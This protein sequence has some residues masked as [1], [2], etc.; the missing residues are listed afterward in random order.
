MAENLHPLVLIHGLTF[1]RSTWQPLLDELAR[2]QPDRRV[3]ALDLPGHG[4]APRALSYDLGDV[5]TYVHDAAAA[6]HL[7]APILV[8]HSIG[9][10]VALIYAARFPTAAVVNLDQ[11]L[12]T[13]PFSALLHTLRPELEGPDFQA[14]W[15]RFRN[16]MGFD[17]LD[18]RM[19][20][21]VLSSHRPE[22]AL[23]VGYWQGVFDESPDALQARVDASLRMLADRRTPFT[24]V[25][26]RPVDPEY[27][28][29]LTRSVPQVR[30]ERFERSGH[31]PQLGDP[32]R[33]AE[34]LATLP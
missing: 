8:G 9:A 15:E 4:D 24:Y 32:R 18:D 27:A 22:Q 25:S 17:Q 19:R 28:E 6:A 21:L 3:L 1:D 16:S 5:A 14:A 33:L 7:D 30:I 20:E 11:P 34:L 29:W 2:I 10:I 13:K 26:G 31:F 23:V 12:Y